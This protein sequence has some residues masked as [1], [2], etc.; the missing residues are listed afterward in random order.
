M[1]DSKWRIP[2]VKR[3]LVLTMFCGLAFTLASPANAQVV[4]CAI[5]STGAAIGAVP[6][7][8]GVTTNA[9]DAGHTEVGASGVNGIADVAGGGRVRI[10]CTNSGAAVNPGVVA[11]TVGFGVPI[12]N[13]QAH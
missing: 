9:S 6:A 8:P 2:V 10:T 4:S 3:V 13:N 5:T 12:T 11:L 7:L 1:P